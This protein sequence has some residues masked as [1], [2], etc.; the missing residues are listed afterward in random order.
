MLKVTAEMHKRPDL[1]KLPSQGPKG[2]AIKKAIVT[3]A[4]NG[5]VIPFRAFPADRLL[6]FTANIDGKAG[7]RFMFVT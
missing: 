7:I 1:I 6:A 5:D 4:A 2:E 3:V